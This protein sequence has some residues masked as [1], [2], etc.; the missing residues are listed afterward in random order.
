[1]RVRAAALALLLAAATGCGSGDNPV[2][3]ALGK[4]APGGDPRGLTGRGAAPHASRSPCAEATGCYAS[5][6]RVGRFDAT[7]LPEAS[8]LAASWRDR[9]VLWLVD[10][11]PGTSELWAVRVDG[12][13]LGRVGVR[14]LDAVNAEALA[15]G[16]C[17][18][19]EPEPCLY[20]GDIGDNTGQRE[21]VRV[22][23]VREPDLRDGPPAEP[24][25][26]DEIHL[27][28]PD[29]P[30]GGAGDRASGGAP[31]SETLLIDG[32]GVPYLVTKARFDDASGV[33]GPTRL[34]A[35]PGFADGELVDLG[36]LTVPPPP[37]AVASLLYGNVVTGGD[38]RPG[39]V[40]L[41]TYDH[42]VEYTA[43]SPGAA[44][45]SLPTWAHEIAPSPWQP[46]AEALAY[47]HERCGYFLA[48]ER[49]GDIWFTPCRMVA[50]DG[51]PTEDEGERA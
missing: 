10:D 22:L 21:S 19:A 18:S 48:G 12:M 30:P 16:P 43:P 20:V 9:D 49:S 7:G 5:P 26:A 4:F 40:L 47:A 37:T 35:A 25:E 27:R 23:R 44:L 17:G 11:R 29:R 36:V 41:R 15:T 24:L 31:D 14:G 38:A 1:M 2:D 32:D 50:P 46:Q 28:Y 3:Q 39:K 13:L 8:G 34:Y 51:A 42:V 45:G 6:V 33:T